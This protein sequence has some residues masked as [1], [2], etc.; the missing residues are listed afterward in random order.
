MLI[1]DSTDNTTKTKE[2]FKDE[3]I[4]EEEIMKI[5]S[6]RRVSVNR[7]NALFLQNRRNTPE[8]I[9]TK[10]KM[11]TRVSISGIMLNE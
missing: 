5:N 1:N 8:E 3:I 9:F 6:G 4:S 10:R 11:S 7:A 2:P